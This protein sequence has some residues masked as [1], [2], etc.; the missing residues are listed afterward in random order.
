MAIFLSEVY[1][2]IEDENFRSHNQTSTFQLFTGYFYLEQIECVD[3]GH[4]GPGLRVSKM[5][6]INV[7][8]INE[9]PFDISLNSNFIKENSPIGQVLGELS[10]EDVDSTEVN[11]NQTLKM[12][13]FLIISSYLYMYVISN[14]FF[15]KEKDFEYLFLTFS[16]M[17]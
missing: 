14:D 4:G 1:T 16:N 12:G 5:F 8:N 11:F 10:A 3:Y 7:T 2:C 15:Q 17:N 9:P 13:Y 6:V